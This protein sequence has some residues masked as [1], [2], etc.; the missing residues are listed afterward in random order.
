MPSEENAGSDSASS[1]PVYIQLTRRGFLATQLLRHVRQDAGYDDIE[2][3]VERIA[4][5]GECFTQ[6]E[7][8]VLLLANLNEFPEPRFP[9]GL[10][11]KTR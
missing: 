4:G 1:R 10:L 11:R 2:Q 6:A 8:Q 7:R 9:D 5:R 3:L